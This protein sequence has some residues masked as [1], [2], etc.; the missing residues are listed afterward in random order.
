V[1]DNAVGFMNG[2]VGSLDELS[3]TACASQS[4][5]PFQFNEMA[6]MGKSYIFKDYLSFQILYSV[7]S[8]LQ[9]ISIIHFIMEFPDAFAD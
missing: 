4:H 8:F 9:T 2:E 6:P 1:T 3:M 5:P 7:T